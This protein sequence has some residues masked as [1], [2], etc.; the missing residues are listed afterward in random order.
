[1][2]V[3]LAIGGSTNGIIHLTAIAG[4]C[5]LDVD[6]KALD[7]MGRENTVLV[8]L[9]PSGQ[10]YNGRFPSCGRHGDTAA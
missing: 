3:L 8:D 2:R 7:R 4:R 5:G 1:M 6:L 9:K 10:H